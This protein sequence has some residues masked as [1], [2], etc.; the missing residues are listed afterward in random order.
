MIDLSEF[1]IMNGVD[2]IFWDMYNGCKLDR[3]YPVS[4]YRT[5]QLKLP[6]RCGKT[7]Y[8]KGLANHLRAKG[9]NTLVLTRNENMCREFEKDTSGKI[10][11]WS[12]GNTYLFHETQSRGKSFNL[13]YGVVLFDEVQADMFNKCVENICSNYTVNGLVSPHTIFFGLY[14]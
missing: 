12:S 8:L 2:S 4:E 13:P 6:R 14:T 9:I 1:D 3:M 5:C 11:V 7:T 10:D